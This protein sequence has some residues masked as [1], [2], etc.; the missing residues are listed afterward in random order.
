MVEALSSNW[1]QIKDKYNEKSEE[2]KDEMMDY[3][4]SQIENLGSTLFGE[5][6]EATELETLVNALSDADCEKFEE[7]VK[8]GMVLS[9]D[10]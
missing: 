6:T 1:P 9:K 4:N 3:F 2:E 5:D 10:G 7:T 8:E